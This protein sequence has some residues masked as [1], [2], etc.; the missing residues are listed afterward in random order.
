MKQTGA[1]ARVRPRFG[2]PRP[3]G[4]IGQKRRPGQPNLTQSFGVERLN[5]HPGDWRKTPLMGQFWNHLTATRKDVQ[6]LIKYER[7]EVHFNLFKKI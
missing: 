1:L 7:V 4:H 2:R 3:E 5:Y 6:M